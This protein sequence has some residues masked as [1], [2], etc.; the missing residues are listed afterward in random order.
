MAK[1]KPVPP[2]VLNR[3]Q[4]K[5]PLLLCG[6]QLIGTVVL[7]RSLKAEP[8]DLIPEESKERLRASAPKMLGG[9][10]FNLCYY[11]DDRCLETVRVMQGARSHVLIHGL[12]HDTLG[13]AV[14]ATDSALQEEF[15]ALSMKLRER[16]PRAWMQRWSIARHVSRKMRDW[17][18]TAFNDYRATPSPPSIILAVGEWPMIGLAATNVD[19]LEYVQ[20]GEGLVL[21]VLQ[22]PAAD[23]VSII[24]CHLRP[25]KK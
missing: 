18:G 3:F 22:D 1:T 4:P 5:P 25:A 7:M 19:R 17:V 20:E 9:A 23:D 13:M 15:N 11:G 14:L 2:I 16:P 6:L 10:Q 21:Y 8:D 12:Q 24:A